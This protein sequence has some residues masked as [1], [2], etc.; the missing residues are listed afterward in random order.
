MKSHW[1]IVTVIAGALLSGC[2]K[3]GI[4]IGDVV[5]ATDTIT[6]T[7]T[8]E[9]YKG[10]RGSKIEVDGE[11]ISTRFVG[12]EL[13]VVEVSE[14]H[15]LVRFV[16]TEGFNEGTIW[17]THIEAINHQTESVETEKGN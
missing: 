3:S 8:I 13:T 1:V 2:G 9:T 17:W 15:D 10:L 6:C 11:T 12:E 16:V 14:E 4:E 7:D 5:V